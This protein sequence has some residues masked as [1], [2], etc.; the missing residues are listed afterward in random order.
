MFYSV[1]IMT[2]VKTLEAGQSSQGTSAPITPGTFQPGTPHELY[3]KVVYHTDVV[4]D[5]K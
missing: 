4:C 2:H 1:T 3:S 5:Q